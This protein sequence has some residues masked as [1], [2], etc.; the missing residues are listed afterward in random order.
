M[1]ISFYREKKYNKLKAFTLVELLIAVTIFTFISLICS[2][3]ALNLSSY[4]KLILAQK[5]V[6]DAVDLSV[7]TMMR[8]VQ[9][10]TFYYA[11]NT[12]PASA[13]SSI[14]RFI[15]KFATSTCVEYKVATSSANNANITYSKG[16]SQIVRTEYSIPPP[17]PIGTLLDLDKICTSYI[18]PST[19]SSSFPITSRNVNITRFYATSTLSSANIPVASVVVDGVSQDA[20]YPTFRLERSVSQRYSQ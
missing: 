18:I 14:F 6:Y 17:L 1:L 2:I 5:T 19:A 13:T 4:N 9:D 16:F 3:I 15:P 7:G 12:S 11:S 20:P 8:E 10:G